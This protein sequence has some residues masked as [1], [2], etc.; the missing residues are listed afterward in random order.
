M[1]LNHHYS[2]EQ[3]VATFNRAAALHKDEAS[4]QHGLSAVIRDI[5]DAARLA[6]A[7]DLM[8]Y[9]HRSL[10]EFCAALEYAIR[11]GLNNQIRNG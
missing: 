2:L 7:K 6:A 4:I 11:D 8:H 9:D 10:Y 5:T 3:L 1:R